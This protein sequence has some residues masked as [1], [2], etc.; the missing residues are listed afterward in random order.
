MAT[1]KES[2][3][4]SSHREAADKGFFTSMSVH[5]DGRATAKPSYPGVALMTLNL[6]T[7]KKAA[8]AM[9][10]IIPDD[11]NVVYSD[12][13]ISG[14]NKDEITMNLTCSTKDSSTPVRFL[15]GNFSNDKTR[16]SISDGHNE[17]VNLVVSPNSYSKLP[18]T[19]KGKEVII[20]DT[21]LATSNA[22]QQS[23]RPSSGT[24]YT[25]TIGKPRVETMG[26][27]V[28]FDNSN[29]IDLLPLPPQTD[30]PTSACSN[31]RDNVMQTDSGDD[32]ADCSSCVSAISNNA[33][34]AKQYNIL[35][36]ISKAIFSTKIY[37]TKTLCVPPKP[38]TVHPNFT[39]CGG[40]EMFF[41]P[42]N[43]HT[44]NETPMHIVSAMACPCVD[45]AAK[46]GAA[47]DMVT[48]MTSP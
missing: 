43:V 23:A 1:N 7:G 14:A 6:F 16:F 25:I 35:Y 28:T 8:E 46:R 39:M 13:L 31:I 30:G 4:M 45:T 42:H 18:G 5:R 24:C 41:C 47:M 38:V 29:A 3:K 44:L 36:F 40:S 37:F 32:V 12:M 34:A 33:V 17:M 2:F 21:G 11:K 19:D 26:Y 48:I 15:L 27:L 10:Q 22:A 9:V 20:G